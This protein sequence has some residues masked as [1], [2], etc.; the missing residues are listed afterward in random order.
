MNS[1]VEAMLKRYN[2]KNNEERENAAKEIIQEIAL[3]GLSR[4]GF[5]KKLLSMVGRVSESSMDWIDSARTW[6]SLCSKKIRISNSANISPLWKG[7]L[8]PME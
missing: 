4:G 6:I 3:A 7:N 2:P 5:F 1:I 8:L